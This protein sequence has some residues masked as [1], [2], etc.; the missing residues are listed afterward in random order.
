MLWLWLL[1]IW[2]VLISGQV[3]LDD[4]FYI[5]L[6]LL[7]WL[8]GVSRQAMEEM[9]VFAQQVEVYRIQVRLKQIMAL[10][11]GFFNVNTNTG[12]WPL[13]GLFFYMRPIKWPLRL[14]RSAAMMT[15]MTTMTTNK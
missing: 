12:S 3:R 9:L 6:R 7:E 2:L 14:S 11:L 1:L 10:S 13:N 15:T 4:C 5:G 8:D